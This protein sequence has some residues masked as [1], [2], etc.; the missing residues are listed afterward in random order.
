M[1]CYHMCIFCIP[2]R[3]C[4]HFVTVIPTQSCMGNCANLSELYGCAWRHP[5]IRMD[6]C[7]CMITHGECIKYT[8]NHA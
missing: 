2:F 8:K 3:G 1:F 7:K 6:N 5:E 4:R